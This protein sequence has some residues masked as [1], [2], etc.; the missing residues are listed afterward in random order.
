MLSEVGGQRTV[1]SEGGSSSPSQILVLISRDQ[2]VCIHHVTRDVFTHNSPLAAEMGRG[3]SR[4]WAVE[5]DV[6]IR[7]MNSIHLMECTGPFISH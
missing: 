5:E 7:V 3:H 6:G 1:R 2:H 4:T